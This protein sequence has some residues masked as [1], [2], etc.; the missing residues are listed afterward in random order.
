MRQAIVGL[1]LC[2]CFSVISGCVTP[3]HGT[4][5]PHSEVITPT[6]CFYMGASRNTDAEPEAIG[7]LRIA[8]V[9]VFNDERMEWGKWREQRPLSKGPYQEVWRV[10]YA[11]NPSVPPAKPFSCI[12]YGKVPLGYKAAGKKET[13]AALPLIPERLYTTLIQHIGGG[14]PHTW[15]NFIIR[16]DST[17]NPI[18]LEYQDDYDG[19]KFHTIIPQ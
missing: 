10:E 2:M 4:I 12:T 15:V 7:V 11:P 13:A 3:R 8:Q 9:A 6:F 19:T 5:H 16:S 17:G 14:P 18:K 1:I